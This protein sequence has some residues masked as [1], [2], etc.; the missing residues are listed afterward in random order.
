MDILEVLLLVCQDF[1]LILKALAGFFINIVSKSSLFK[2][3][4]SKI[5]ENLFSISE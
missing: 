4:S 5:F 1:S 2:P 3:F